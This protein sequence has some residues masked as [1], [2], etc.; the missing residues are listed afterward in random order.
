MD[1]GGNPAATGLPAM[2]VLHVC[3]SIAGGTGTYLTELIPEQVR[4][5]GRGN[6]C[7]IAPDS[8]TDYFEAALLDSGVRIE[9][10]R[11]PSRASGLYF[12]R[13]AIEGI[14]S[15]FRPDIVHAHSTGAGIV[16]R[17]IPAR[18]AYKRIYC[19]HGWSFDIPGSR[20]RRSL[21][22]FAER[23]LAYRADRIVA[24]SCFEHDRGVAIGIPPEKIVTI[25]NGVADRPPVERPAEWPTD[26]LK[27]LFVGRFDRQ[28]G[29]DILL[30]AVEPLG[31]RVS[32][33]AVGAPVVDKDWV[34]Y[35][36]LPFVK[37][38]GWLHRDEVA[39]QMA[40]A[41]IL[42]VPSRWEG[43]GLVAVEAL[44]ASLPVV[45]ASVGGLTEILDHGQYGFLFP[46]GD[47]L[48][49][50]RL[51]DELA[52]E[53]LAAMRRDIRARY[54]ELY[55]ADRMIDEIHELYEA[56][57]KEGRGERPAMVSTASPAA[58]RPFGSP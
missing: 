33:R 30:D 29:L 18:G 20:M 9:T 23:M 25:P 19:A 40:A 42:V 39:A 2:R 16:T 6:V 15:D 31:E 35:P 24:I 58:E 57:L 3:D 45:A 41:D 10:F 50:R 53:R 17:L 5:L 55:T 38:L 14:V 46:A 32:V 22:S 49:L 1:A 54:L 13:N 37:Y 21:I 7:L 48:T 26:R 52:P 51:L 44:R 27:I 56:V 4:R 11:R 8:Q 47:S 43:F 12:L 28:K 34:H 36:R